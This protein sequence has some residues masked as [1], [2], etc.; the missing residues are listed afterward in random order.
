[1]QFWQFSVDFRSHVHVGTADDSSNLNVLQQN[2]NKKNLQLSNATKFSSTGQ[3]MT[4]LQ[5][6]KV[7]WF[8]EKD[9]HRQCGKE[10]VR[11]HR[12]A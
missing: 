4:K 9:C 12:V 11:R 3:E 2:L 7:E 6:F 10:P 5:Q 8:G 1:M